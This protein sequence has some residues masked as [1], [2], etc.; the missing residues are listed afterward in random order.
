M[1]AITVP[2]CD[3]FSAKPGD[4]IEWTNIQPGCT[5][6][7]DGSN[8]W[9]FTVPP[10]ITPPAP[11]GVGIKIGLPPGTYCFIVSCCEKTRVC[12]TIT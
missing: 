11:G 6:S 1:P 10:P 8:P 5:V 2:I 3:S 7:Q 12:I 9:P 4:I